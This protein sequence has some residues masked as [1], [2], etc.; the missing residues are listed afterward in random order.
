[1]GR[2]VV[3]G[4]LMFVSGAV[5][6]GQQAGNGRVNLVTG[7]AVLPVLTSSGGGTLGASALVG[8]VWAS[9]HLG[10]VHWPG[11]GQWWL[12][13]GGP[14]GAAITVCAAWAIRHLGTFALT[15]GVVVGQM[16]TAVLVDL[17]TGVPTR[18]ATLVAV[19]LVTGATLLVV[20]P[21]RV[22]APV[23]R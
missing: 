8:V 4:A 2:V 14:L 18:W 12:Y 20:V 6:A 22:A 16:V 3:L 10:A 11:P 5:L 13:L 7:D 17:L 15:L 1:V 23:A 9:G 19:L 21:R